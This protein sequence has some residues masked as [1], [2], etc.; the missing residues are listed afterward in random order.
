[1]LML[2]SLSL[3][4]TLHVYSVLLRESV[5]LSSSTN[6]CT[7]VPSLT[8]LSD[9]SNHWRDSTGNGVKHLTPDV[10]PSWKTLSPVILMATIIGNFNNTYC[11]H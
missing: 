2:S 6:S 11:I 9:W 10:S 3:S 4:L 8:A 1:M 7:D 5:M